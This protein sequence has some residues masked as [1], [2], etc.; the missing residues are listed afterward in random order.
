MTGNIG[1]VRALSENCHLADV[2]TLPMT[3]HRVPET[4]STRSISYATSAETRGGRAVIRTVENATGRLGLIRRARGYEDE[5]TSG[6]DFWEV[7]VARMGVQLE[8]VSGS[9]SEI[10]RQ[11]PLVVVA[12]HP[13]GVLDGLVMGHILS[14]VRGRNFRILA[15]SVFRRAAELEE[16]VLP[17]HFAQ[18]EEALLANIET[19]KVALRHLS[20]GGAIGVFPG[21]TV[22]TSSKPFG[23]PMDPGWRSFTAKMISRSGAAVVPIYFDGANSRIFQIASHVHCTL[24]LALL[25]REFRA[26]SREPVR[27]AIGRP[28][29]PALLAHY[30]H[31]PRAMMDFLRRETYALSPKPIRDMGYGFEFEARHRAT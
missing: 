19:R 24:R 3:A 15:N 30:R 12:N 16:V 14:E 31:H 10:P 23:R 18:T 17:I 25:L 21:G 26:K 8:M 29:D 6:R 22:S 5:L 9:L 4:P 1:R 28:I 13:Y 7:M 11:E 20:L 2:V 27:V